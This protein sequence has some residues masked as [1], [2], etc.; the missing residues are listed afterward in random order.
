MYFFFRRQ[1]TRNPR[2]FRCF[3]LFFVLCMF[4]V[5]S[6]IL[7]NFDDCYYVVGSCNKSKTC[8]FVKLA[9]H[10][11]RWRRRPCGKAL[12]KG[13]T[14]KDNT[15]RL[16]PNKIYCYQS[17]EKFVDL[18]VIIPGWDVISVT[19][20]SELAESEFLTTTRL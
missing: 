6:V 4:F 20:L 2:V 14:V 19:E 7:H 16:Y 12:L 13:V 1:S 3:S 9:N 8:S 10:R 15:K 11:Q 5:Q 18:L 17:V